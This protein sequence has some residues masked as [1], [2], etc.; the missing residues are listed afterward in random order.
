MLTPTV[1]DLA[2]GHFYPFG[3]TPAVNFLR[4]YRPSNSDNVDIL[5][6]GCGDA[7]N[8]LFSL[9]SEHKGNGCKFNFTVCDLNPAV[10]G[11]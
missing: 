5:A 9:R 2:K 8:L 1:V 7:R 11:K 3:N 4:D 6:L 10:F